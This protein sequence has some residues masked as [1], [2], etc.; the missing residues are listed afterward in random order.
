MVKKEN[1]KRLLIKRTF[2]DSVETLLR[3]GYYLG[4]AP[5]KEVS[6]ESG[7]LVYDW[8]S[9]EFVRTHSFD[10]ICLLLLSYSYVELNT[11][12]IPLVPLIF[13]VWLKAVSSGICRSIKNVFTH[14]DKFDRN[15]L[16]KLCTEFYKFDKTGHRRHTNTILMLLLVPYYLIYTLVTLKGKV[17]LHHE[18]SFWVLSA[19]LCCFPYHMN[20]IV[21]INIVNGMSVRLNAIEKQLK[22]FKMDITKGYT[23]LNS[24]AKF[25]EKIR[26]LYGDLISC[27]NEVNKTYGSFLFFTQIYVTVTAAMTFDATIKVSSTESKVIGFICFYQLMTCFSL[28]IFAARL[29]GQVIFY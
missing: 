2:Y 9:K 10:L 15:Y 11:P 16:I 6:P 18:P 27:C 26:S 21:F 23:N 29:P 28:V 12:F 13:I 17:G 24:Q 4:C 14:F 20:C 7:Y 1:K 22:Y 8:T 5:F 19:F 3:V 25:F